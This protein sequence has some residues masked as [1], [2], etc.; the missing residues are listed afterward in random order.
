MCNA[1]DEL[2][3]GARYVVACTGVRVFAMKEQMT[4]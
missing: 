1:I 4:L 2:H 3:G